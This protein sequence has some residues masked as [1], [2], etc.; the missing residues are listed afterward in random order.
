MRDGV[1]RH[2]QLVA[3]QAHQQMLRHILVPQHIDFLLAVARRLPL[4]EH[5]L[6][7]E[8]DYLDEKSASA[9][10]PKIVLVSEPRI[11][12][13]SGIRPSGREPEEPIDS[14][15]F[16]KPACPGSVSFVRRNLV[17]DEEEPGDFDASLGRVRIGSVQDD[18]LPKTMAC[19]SVP[20]L[21]GRLRTVPNKNS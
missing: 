19:L 2:Q 11:I 13:I 4:G 12:P 16:S 6:V 18:A 5:R 15:A 7:N 9:A 20:S 17:H 1:W 21:A 3:V 14:Y 8:I 10:G